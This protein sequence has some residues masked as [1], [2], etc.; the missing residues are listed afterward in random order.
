V[1]VCQLKSSPHPIRNALCVFRTLHPAL[2]VW[3]LSQKRTIITFVTHRWL[4]PRTVL[5]HPPQVTQRSHPTRLRQLGAVRP[6]L[7][8]TV[9]R[10][11]WVP[12][13]TQRSALLRRH[14]THHRVV[15]IE[16]PLH[17]RLVFIQAN[18][19][20]DTQAQPITL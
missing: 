13:P 4:P 12:L 18:S 3:Q 6:L 1:T 9:A 15:E 10:H 11:L 2:P 8:V 19:C 16:Q 5:V 20:N 14:I 17:Q 7:L